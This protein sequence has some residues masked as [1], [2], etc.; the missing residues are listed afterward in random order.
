[1][2]RRSEV[3]LRSKTLLTETFRQTAVHGVI[4]F[5]LPG[6]R[7]NQA[8]TLLSG[9]TCE[10]C[11]VSNGRAEISVRRGLQGRFPLPALSPTKK[12]ETLGLRSSLISSGLLSR[13]YTQGF[14]DR[15]D[16]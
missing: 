1:M 11:I 2:T 16:E 13:A 12:S 15:D 7:V 6:K 3:I 5:H 8:L 14:E 9:G 4:Q 10:L